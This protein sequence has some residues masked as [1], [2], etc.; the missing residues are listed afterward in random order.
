M[1][2]FLNGNEWFR[3]VEL[4]VNNIDVNVGDLHMDEN[5]CGSGS[6]AIMMT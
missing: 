2:W 3:D 4:M 6:A 5:K 1:T